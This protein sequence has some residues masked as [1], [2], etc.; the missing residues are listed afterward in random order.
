MSRIRITID[1]TTVGGI[2]RAPARMNI[3]VTIVR[4]RRQISCTGHRVGE[5]CAKA[6][7]AAIVVDVDGVANVVIAVDVLVDVATT[8][9]TP[10]MSAHSPPDRLGIRSVGAR[11]LWRRV[12]NCVTP[13]RGW[14]DR[15]CPTGVWKQLSE[16]RYSRP[17]MIKY[18]TVVMRQFPNLNKLFEG[19]VNSR[20]VSKRTGWLDIFAPIIVYTFG[21]PS[22]SGEL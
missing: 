11:P 3:G 7:R 14:R 16:A 1:C 19:G 20:N 13:V 5:L 10:L 18:R 17:A 22:V 15:P 8:A 6:P 9:L 21:D 4:R 2:D 12:A